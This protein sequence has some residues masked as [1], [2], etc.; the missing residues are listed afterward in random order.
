MVCNCLQMLTLSALVSASGYAL[1]DVNLAWCWQLRDAEI[2]L[3]L[4]G[5][6]RLELLDLTGL[7]ELTGKAFRCLQETGVTH[8][9][10]SLIRLVIKG[11]SLV[12]DE[13]AQD[14]VRECP[15]LTVVNYWGNDMRHHSVDNVATEGGIIQH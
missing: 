14:L 10:Q 6:P 12:S 2:T 13:V 11:C 15:Q 9:S 4:E 8:A 1:R 3:L 5:S 7:E